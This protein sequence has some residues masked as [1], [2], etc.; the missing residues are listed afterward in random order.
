M[1]ITAERQRT[2]WVSEHPPT[3]SLTH[4]PT[5]P[6]SRLCGEKFDGAHRNGEDMKMENKTKAKLKRGEIA[7]GHFILEFDT[8]GVGQM[9]ANAGCE[10]VI[11][12]MEHSSLTQESI[13]W[14][15]LSAKAAGITPLVRV[16]YTEYFL[17]SR[18]LDA[19]A[20]GLMIPRVE[21]RDQ[22]LRIIESTK[23]PPVGNRGAAFG[24]AHDDYR[25]VD[26]AAAA[27]QANEETLIIVQTETAKAIENVD[28]ILSVDGVD[29]AWIGQCDLTISLGIPGQYDHP[30]FLKAFDR[31][32]NACEKHGVALGYLPLSVPEAMAM[33]DKG[34]R[35]IAYSADVFLFSSVLKNDIQ[36]IQEHV[37]K[38]DQC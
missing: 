24:I 36:K 3:H 32:L 26:I 29:V 27:R 8:P 33:I 28:E 18:P 17:M 31:V 15:V 5:Y 21:T 19:G 9:I 25:G 20:E 12:D 16:P 35:C 6:S 23:Y 2:E 30:T 14:S 10:F 1:K 4:L 38:L 13:R 22:T 7:V 11:F 34:V 37:A